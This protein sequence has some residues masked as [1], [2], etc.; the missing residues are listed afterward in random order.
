MPIDTAKAAKIWTRYSYARDN[1]HHNFVLKADKCDRFFRGDQWEALDKARLKAQRRPAL[2]INKIISTLTNVMGEQI[3]NRSEI[4]FRP[5]SGSP[6]EVADVLAK[7]FKQISDNNQLDWKRSDMF[8]DGV[9][10]SRGFLDVRIAFNDHM[11]G[12]VAI[13]NLNMKN[14]VIDPDAEDYDPDK[15]NEVF[16]TKWVTPDDIAVLYSKEDY[17]LLKDRAQ[18]SL[19]YGYDSIVDN[20][21]DRFGN[22]VTPAYGNVYDENGVTRSIRLLERQYRMLDNQEHFVSP[23]TGDMRQVPE[24]FDRNRK[25]WFVEKFGFQIVK[26]LVTRI[27]WTVVADNVVLHDEWSP[28]KH[29]TVVPYFPLFR[30]GTTIGL[31]ENLLDPQE[32]LNKSSSQELHIANTTAN[33]GWITRSGA[34]TNL[35]PEE[36]EQ[37]GAETGL[38]IE[39]GGSGTID[40]QI[41]KIKPNQVPQALDRI[42]YK[43]EEH[44][45]TISNVGDSQ[46]GQDRAD[47]A[48]KAIQAKRQAGNT[49]LA[50]PLDSLVRSDFILARNT[51][52]LIQGFYTEERLLTITNS[53][54]EGTTE[55]MAIN[56]VT[57][58]GRVVNDLTLGEYDA[59]IS[60]V[61]QRETLE[62]SQFDQAISMREIGV[63]LPDEV[64]IENS[65]LINKKDIL[66]KMN[67]GKNTPEAQRAAAARLK[68]QEAEAE[69]TVGEARAKH[70]DADLKLAKADK[71]QAEAEAG[72]ESDGG[73]EIAKAGAEIDLNERR[74]D[75]E[76]QMDFAELREKQRGNVVQERLDAHMA[77]EKVLTERAAA[78]HAAAN[79]QPTGANP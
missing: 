15:W 40:E 59:V 72:P 2:T 65:R 60:S 18:S 42:S 30:H 8:A 32:L 35:S 62:D 37:R 55:T 71:E 67:A 44:I 19:P 77:A 48:A 17:E 29:F 47:V 70:A 39:V 12:E 3:F 25:A 10:T 23:E 50:K 56:Q 13:E 54:L 28:Y 68:T 57:P 14:V 69:K 20:I 52:D 53:Q 7:V 45:K 9:I 26:K 33:S 51:L 75:H 4:S 34:V 5:R 43:A 24:N 58:E 41:Q 36:L 11:Q 76:K 78:A 16:I 73:A 46:L 61:P 31:V 79:P 27:K 66:A 64:L 49:N 63:S 22:T 21:R 74:F 6:A 38:V 1:G